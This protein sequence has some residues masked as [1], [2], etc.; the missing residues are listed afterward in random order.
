MKQR[1]LTC[2]NYNMYD[3]IVTILQGRCE[4]DQSCMGPFVPT[5]ENIFLALLEQYFVVS[6]G[7]AWG[8]GIAS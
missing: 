5:E 6:S 8:E 7:F 4:Q 1:Y 3:D 2:I